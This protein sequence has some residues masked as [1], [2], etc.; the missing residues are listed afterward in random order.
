MDIVKKLDDFL[1]NLLKEKNKTNQQNLEYAFEKLQN[2]TRGVM[3][4]LAKLWKILEDIKQAE[5]EAVQI[6]VNA[7]LC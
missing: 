1:N 2:K 3:G 6:W 7:L 5:D 4:L